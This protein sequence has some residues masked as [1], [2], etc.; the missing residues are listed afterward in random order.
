M[1]SIILM[2]PEISGNIGAIARAMK[3]FSFTNLILIEPKCSHLNTEAKS[4]AK[5]AI[6]ILKKA[7]VEKKSA[8]KN[9]D[10]LIGTTSALGTDYN[11]PRSPINP[12]NLAELLTAAKGKIGIVFGRE[13]TGLRNKEILMCDFIV[14][15]PTSKKYPA[16]NISH[17]AA[18]ILY[19]IHK[20]SSA[21]KI[22]SHFIFATKKEK[23]IIMRYLDKILSKLEFQTPQKK[24]TQKK[25]WKRLIGKS[26]LTKREAFALI[27]FLRKIGKL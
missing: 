22:D 26:F 20:N 27:G 24:E 11:I 15:I 9:F 23:E 8:L 18:I 2:E 3:N 7:K 10:Y 16:M 6:N 21:K 13:S 12:E 4:R 19:E 1:L 14:T 17:S 25:I 5:H